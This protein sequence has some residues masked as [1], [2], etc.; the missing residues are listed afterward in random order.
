MSQLPSD[1]DEGQEPQGWLPPWWLNDDGP[2]TRENPL[3]GPVARVA[4]A[5]EQLRDL[6]RSVQGFL[7]SEP[8][9]FLSKYYEAKRVCGL[10][11]TARPFPEEWSVILGEFVHNLRSALDHLIWQ[12]V[13]VR[14]NEPIEKQ[15]GFPI[16]IDK[17]SFKN[18]R[19]DGGT[20]K[21]QGVA[22]SDVATIE[23]LQPHY[24]RTRDEARREPLFLL[25]KLWNA[26]KHRHPQ[27][28]YVHSGEV[29]Y[30]DFPQ[31][32]ADRDVA[33]VVPIY[34]PVS[35]MQTD[36]Y[37]VAAARVEPTGPD[38]RVKMDRKFPTRI[39]FGRFEGGG[40]TPQGLVNIATSVAGVV[41]ALAP[42]F[43]V[44]QPDVAD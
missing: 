8:Y 5:N 26:D 42:A 20:W 3:A 30:D 13:I 31:I 43:G 29:A 16:T 2:I 12:L 44:T 37:L 10:Y 22:P 38:P 34:G 40:I 32:V 27:P 7:D 19:R 11:A 23:L 25:N 6:L 35:H 9:G 18:D 15:T 14:G 17:G 1:A 33:S 21:L 41:N 24:G 4:R 39:L 28:V 36:G